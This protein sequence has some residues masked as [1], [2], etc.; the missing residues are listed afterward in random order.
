MTEEI[1]N[2][3]ERRNLKV[4]IPKSRE[5]ILK[6]ARKIIQSENQLFKQIQ[7]ID[8]FLANLKVS[9]KMN[10]KKNYNIVESWSF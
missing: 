2:I 1:F 7:D 10:K 3:Y 9:I 6:Y 8:L 4:D 5:E